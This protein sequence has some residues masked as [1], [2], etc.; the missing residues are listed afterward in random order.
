VTTAPS[1][2]RCKGVMLSAL[3]GDGPR[4]MATAPLRFTKVPG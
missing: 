4:P 1:H 3:A 2:L